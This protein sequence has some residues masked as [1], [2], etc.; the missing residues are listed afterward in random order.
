MTIAE[1]K[2]ALDSLI[3]VAAALGGAGVIWRYIWVPIGKGVLN[4]RAFFKHLCKGLDTI[5]A[6]AKE[7]KTNGGGSLKDDLL[8]IK[9]RIGSLESL[10]SAQMEDDPQ[11]VFICDDQ[12]SNVFL[13]RTYCRLLGVTKEELSGQSWR[14]FVPHTVASDYEKLWKEAFG[15]NREISTD[16]PL[17]RA[18]GKVLCS[19]VSIFP[20]SKNTDKTRRFLGRIKVNP[21]CSG[22]RCLI[23]DLCPHKPLP[24]ALLAD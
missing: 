16:I 1:F 23:G 12:G 15:S 4:A 8:Q 24:K 6:L 7:V 5:E 21:S 18:D 19:H 9:E 17:Q 14:A 20:L 11:G 2:P 13:N 3:L 10:V 22:D